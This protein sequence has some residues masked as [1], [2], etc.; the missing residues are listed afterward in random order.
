MLGG[1]VAQVA[2]P[3]NLYRAPTTRE[4]AAFVGEANFIPGEANGHTVDCA[5]GRLVLDEPAVG[6]VSV[7]LRPEWLRLNAHDAQTRGVILWREFYGHDQRIGIRLSDETL[8]VVRSAAGEDY[9]P[10]ETVR[11]G[12]NVAVRAYPRE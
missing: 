4:V 1:R 8:L 12:V 9:A 11:V 5:L 3:Q 2:T 10:G 6:A 7:L